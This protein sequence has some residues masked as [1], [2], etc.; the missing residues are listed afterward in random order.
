MLLK[1]DPHTDELQVDLGIFEALLAFGKLLGM[2]R[3]VAS[4]FALLYSQDSA[5]TVEE[6]ADYSNLSKS[7]VSLALR[8]LMQLGAVQETTVLGERCRR[9][10]GLSDV[11]QTIKNMVVDRL[12][13]PIS[14]LEA[15]LENT[16]ESVRQRQ[17]QA[18]IQQTKQIMDDL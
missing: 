15:R 4:V 8:D 16:A 1:D 9:Y 14:D 12:K 13:Y 11:G 6:I 18:L 3:S 17:L 5:C 2:S 7:A 10:A